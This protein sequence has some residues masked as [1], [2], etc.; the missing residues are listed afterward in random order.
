MSENVEDFWANDEFED[1]VAAALIACF[2]T[3]LKKNK[4]APPSDRMSLEQISAVR[5]CGPYIPSNSRLFI[6]PTGGVND[7]ADWP[8]DRDCDPLPTRGL[9]A[10]R[11]NLGQLKRDPSIYISM[12]YVRKAKALGRNW[13]TR[14]SGDLYEMFAIEA[15]SSG[16]GG[17]RKFFTVTKSGVVASC[18]QTFGGCLPGGHIDPIFEI[19]EVI[20]ASSAMASIALQAISDRRH[21]WTIT[22]QEAT[23]RA[24]LG[25]MREEIKSLLYARSLPMTSTGRKRPILHLVEAHK[26][27]MRAGTDVDVTAFLRGQQ[28]VEI[29]GTVFTVTPPA[30]LRPEV[31]EPSRERYFPPVHA[32]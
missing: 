24:H 19:E 7:P 31:S 12:T 17:D 1:T 15:N 13:H 28:T 10:S 21:S 29:G 3:K 8:F 32:E 11:P 26:R 14:K 23:A 16:V 27:R 30:T 4:G 5:A 6:G 25:C 22:A 18:T 9:F 2:E 20:F